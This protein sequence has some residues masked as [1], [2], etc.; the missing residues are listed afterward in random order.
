MAVCEALPQQPQVSIVPAEETTQVLPTFEALTLEA[1]CGPP[2]N[3]I[4]YRLGEDYLNSPYPNS[5]Y[6]LIYYGTEA[7]M[8]NYINP[9]SGG[10]SSAITSI[11]YNTF[12]GNNS[13]S[14][15]STATN[16][17]YVRTDNIGNIIYIDS[18]GTFA[19]IAPMSKKDELRERIRRNLNSGPAILKIRAG[20]PVSIEEQRARNLLRRIIGEREYALFLRKGFLTVYGKTGL[21]YQIPMGSGMIACYH[22]SKKGKYKL[23]QR[24]CVQFV[25]HALP[26]TDALIMRKLLIE[27]DEV[28]LRKRSNV[29]PG[30]SVSP[31]ERKGVSDFLVG[32]A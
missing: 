1:L 30:N 31:E 14:S 26:P 28:E 12:T 17:M 23:F 24:I 20:R 32:A 3:S 27:N 22:P 6:P 16:S 9:S 11:V 29:F 4:I 8:N 10:A 13:I 2:H 5:P 21:V 15:Y 25:D 7:N 18:I 19:P